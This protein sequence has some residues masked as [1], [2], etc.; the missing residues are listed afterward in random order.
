[1]TRP[2][3]RDLG[4]EIGIFDTGS[5]NAITDVPGVGVGHSTL[6][7]GEGALAPGKGPVRTG[8]T[9]I[10]PHGGNLFREKVQAGCFVLNGFGKS[11]GLHQIQE[12]GTIETPIALTNTLSVPQVADALIGFAC[13]QSPEIGIST[14]TVNAAVGDINDG[15]LND[16]QGRHVKEK[17]LFEALEAAKQNLAAGGLPAEGNV[18]GGTGCSC[19]GFKGG[20]GTSS[21]RLPARLG[22]W[23]LGVLV[24]TNFGGILSVNGA[25]VGRELGIFDFSPPKSQFLGSDPNNCLGSCMVV[26]ATDAPADSRQL[27]RM[28]RRGGLGMARTGFYSSSGSGDFFIAF[29]VANPVPHGREGLAPLCRTVMQD[30]ALSALF[31]AQAEAIEEAV[32]NSLFAAETMV[33]RDGNRRIAL[34]L[35]ETLA[36]LDRCHARGWAGRL[37]RAF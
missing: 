32:I 10:L 11:A 9:A 6:I 18:G 14:G 27:A 3:A 7:A 36:I 13:A 26:I 25:P 22:G 23:T 34:P 20:I 4:V 8:V 21:R 5:R 24:Q 15:F 31:A 1:M 2:R 17:H 33:G 35:E 19:L 29:S 37:P 30:E 28:A 12:L 16:I